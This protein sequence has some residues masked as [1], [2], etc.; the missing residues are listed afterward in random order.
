MPISA[1]N[2]LAEAMQLPSNLRSRAT[3]VRGRRIHYIAS[4]DPPDAVRPVVLIHGIGLSHRYLV[5]LARVMA[6]EAPVYVPDLPGFGKSEKRWRV[7]SLAELADW[8]AAWIAT[9]GF[10]AVGLLGQS[11]GTQVV[12][13]LAVRR[14]ELVA[15]LVLQG[16]TVDPGGRSLLQ[17]FIRWRRNQ[18]VEKDTKQD[19]PSA[20]PDYARCGLRRIIW[21]YH[22]AIQDRPEELIPQI[23]CPTLVVHGARD[24][25][26]SADWARHVSELLPHGQLITMEG[27][28]HTI[29]LEAPEELARVAMP[30][31]LGSDPPSTQNEATPAER[32]EPDA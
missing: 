30:H 14:P 19:A 3:R 32:A 17:Q 9:L 22:K 2:Y 11:F 7:E 25:I 15:R 27:V 29:N 10:G 21:T 18:H 4:V 31:L 6:E 1:T 23:A 12:I 20:L 26:V 16:T 24:P 8:T 13:H 28:S 5:P